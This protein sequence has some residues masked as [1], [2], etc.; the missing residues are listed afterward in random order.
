MCALQCLAGK[1]DYNNIN[2]VVDSHNDLPRIKQQEII[3]S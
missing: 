3:R 2:T 1:V